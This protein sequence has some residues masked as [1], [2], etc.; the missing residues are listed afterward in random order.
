MRPTRRPEG[1]GFPEGPQRSC[2]TYEHGQVTFV[3]S[4]LPISGVNLFRNVLLLM[5]V[6]ST[7][8][9]QYWQ[10]CNGVSPFSHP[11]SQTH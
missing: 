4:H 6:V 9:I 2:V 3:R 5:A 1:Q 11:V 10:L 7:P 8:S